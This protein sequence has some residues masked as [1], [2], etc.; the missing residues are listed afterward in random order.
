MPAASIMMRDKDRRGSCYRSFL[1]LNNCVVAQIAEEVML[2]IDSPV[3]VDVTPVIARL[4]CRLPI[5]IAF[6]ETSSLQADSRRKWLRGRDSNSRPP[7]YEAGELPLLYPTI[8][9]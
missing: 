3:A 8:R 1:V 2:R 6:E 9:S 7:A 4:Y 5:R